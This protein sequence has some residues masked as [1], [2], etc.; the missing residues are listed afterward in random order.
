[1]PYSFRSEQWLPVP[2]ETV[3]AFFADPEN[4]PALMPPAQRAR[5][6][7]LQLVPA[8]R[9]TPGLLSS[10]AAGIGSRIALS[11]RPV[12]LLPMRIRWLGEIIEFRAGDSF[13][14]RQVRGPFTYWLHKHRVRP[15]GDREAPGVTLLTDEID[16]E[17]PFG[18]LG[19]LSHHF[20][21][22]QIEKS[23]AYRREHLISALA[24][25]DITPAKPAPAVR[26]S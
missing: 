21:H 25:F 15:V 5:I 24:R 18:I 7:K 22:R 13:C 6:D 10:K 17:L 8:P 16:Y 2:V 19:T 20:V 14:D 26:A 12:P 23:F 11:W 1:M 3:F 4:L 9:P